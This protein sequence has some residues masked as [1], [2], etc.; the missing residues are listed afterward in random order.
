MLE[1]IAKRLL[2]GVVTLF[3]ATIVFLLLQRSNPVISRLRDWGDLQHQT[4]LRLSASRTDFTARYMF[5]I[6]IG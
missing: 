1:L 5:A 2:A 6:W 4:T 3:A